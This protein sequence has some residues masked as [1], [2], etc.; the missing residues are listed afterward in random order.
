MLWQCNEKFMGRSFHPLSAGME[1]A[2]TLMCTFL[3]WT[4]G[5][6]GLQADP[7]VGSKKPLDTQGLPRSF[8][9]VVAHS[10]WGLLWG[11]AQ[12]A[13][14][15]ALTCQSVHWFRQHPGWQPAGWTDELSS[16]RP[17]GALASVCRMIPDVFSYKAV[18]LSWALWKTRT[19]PVRRALL[20]GNL[21]SN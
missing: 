14:V 7:A 20:A 15:G 9:A 13:V 4:A 2:C 11:W 5:L 19:S 6:K 1:D 16:V 3:T 21:E 12:T 17:A 10:S 18:L 8:R